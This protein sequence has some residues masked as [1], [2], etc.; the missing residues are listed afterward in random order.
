[1]TAAAQPEPLKIPPAPPEPEHVTPL[2]AP[3]EPH[4]VT[5]T[6][7]TL[8]PVR[9][10]DGLSSERNLPGDLFTATL[11]SP[12]TVG[13]FVIAERGARAG[14]LPSETR[15]SCRLREAVTVTERLR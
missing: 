1:T 13:G 15:V 4:K 6:A 7:G 10:V 9:L 8:I 2:P 14:T 3:P 12:L 11:D 5:L